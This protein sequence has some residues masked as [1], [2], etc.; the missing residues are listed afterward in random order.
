MHWPRGKRAKGRITNQS[1]TGSDPSNPPYIEILQDCKSGKSLTLCGEMDQ[2]HC[3]IS[4][5]RL[6]PHLL[7]FFCVFKGPLALCV[8]P[9]TSTL[10]CS[11]LRFHISVFSS[12]T[13]PPAS[14]SSQHKLVL[15]SLLLIAC[16]FPTILSP[17]SLT[18]ILLINFL[19]KTNRH[20]LVCGNVPKSQTVLSLI[21]YFY[22]MWPLTLLT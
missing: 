3:V 20:V 12:P 1:T 10:C 19:F 17:T 14:S 16:S 21:L 13:P 18:A 22:L 11:L 7:H 8:C 2:L 9:R 5:R 6:M 15:P 4:V